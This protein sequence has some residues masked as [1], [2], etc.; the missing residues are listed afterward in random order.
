MRPQCAVRAAPLALLLLAA[1]AQERTIVGYGTP[2]V[3]TAATGAPRVDYASARLAF[4][5]SSGGRTAVAGSL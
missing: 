2:P 3:D 5:T 1:C 4:T